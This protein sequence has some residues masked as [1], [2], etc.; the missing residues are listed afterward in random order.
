MYRA[1]TPTHIFTLPF[2]TSTCSEILVSYRQK[3]T[4]LDKHYQDGTLPDGMTLDEDKVI[5]S[6]TQD[7]TKKFDRG[8][9]QA[10]LRVMTNGGDVMASQV[11]NLKIREVLNEETLQ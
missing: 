4:A 10:Q 1:T 3:K 9:A 11:F 5:I 8:E 7:E 2:D 6:L